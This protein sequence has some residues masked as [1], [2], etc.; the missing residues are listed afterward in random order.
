V[1]RRTPAF[2]IAAAAAAVAASSAPGASVDP[3]ANAAANVVCPAAPTGWFNPAGP[4]GRFVLTPLDVPGE[5]G[6]YG[7][8]DIEEV[9][10]GYFTSAGKHLIVDVRYALPRDPNPFADFNVGCTLNDLAAGV[11][12][13]AYAWNTTD[14]VYRIV[15]E[16]RWSYA[17]FHD[18]FGQLAPTDVAGFQAIAGSMLHASE[19]N[20][21]E[22]G[23][24]HLGQAVATRS[25][26]AFGFDVTA[27]ANGA[28]THATGEGAF[29]V[30]ANPE[31]GTGTLLDLRA[32]PIA[33]S[34]TA[35]GA[36]PRSVTIRVVAPRDFRSS[37]GAT[38]HARVAVTASTLPVCRVGALGMLTVSTDTDS[39]RLDICGRR[40]LD[41]DGNITLENL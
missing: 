40:L 9:D 26:W 1:L 37:G 5:G 13:G 16:Q 41:A 23:L 30:R 10:C 11:P 38:F 27:T 34:V 19:P 18:F 28:T 25:D 8:S 33:V 36:K 15:S 2:L 3:Y 4:G 6:E 21:H 39:V 29:A 14:R 31:G 35:K 12:N 17:T 22:C 7:G 20:A 24:A 32:Q